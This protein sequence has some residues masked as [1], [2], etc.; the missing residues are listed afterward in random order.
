[1]VTGKEFEAGNQHEP[2]PLRQEK[3]EEPEHQVRSSKKVKAQGTRQGNTL[4]PL[5]HVRVW[6]SQSTPSSQTLK[7]TTPKKPLYI[8]YL[9]LHYL[10]LILEN[11]SSLLLHKGLCNSSLGEGLRCV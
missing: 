11:F 10:W 3:T 6:R 5:T 2:L 8:P 9:Y 4:T 1:M 7:V